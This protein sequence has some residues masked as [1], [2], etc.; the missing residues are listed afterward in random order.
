MNSYRLMSLLLRAGFRTKNQLKIDTEF[1]SRLRHLR[2][3]FEIGCLSSNLT[4]FSDPAWHIV[5]EYDN[6]LMADIESGA[7]TWESLS[8]SIEPD[9][10]YCAKG[11]VENRNRLNKSKKPPASGNLSKKEGDKPSK[12]QMAATESRPMT[13][14]LVY[15]PIIALGANKIGK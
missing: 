2:N 9:S 11:T 4:S 7:K 6:R 3:V 5:R 15:L 10:I 8:N 12:V 14:R 13:E 1:L